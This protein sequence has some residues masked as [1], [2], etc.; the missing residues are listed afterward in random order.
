MKTPR[1]LLGFCLVIA[2]ACGGS[3]D[4]ASGSAP[5]SASSGAASAGS[6]SSLKAVPHEKLAEF[7]PNLSGWK[8][9]A[10]P[11]LDTDTSANVSRVQQSYEKGDGSSISVEIMDAASN[12]QMIVPLR[13][14]L[15]VS[16]TTTTAAGTQK[17]IKVAGH[18]AAEEWAADVRNG[19]V[20]VLLADRFIVTVTGSMVASLDVIHKVF[21]SIDLQKLAALK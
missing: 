17:V 6:S 5:A 14:L 8:R 4:S 9:E 3:A 15:K 18:T 20:A 10:P 7:L 2:G 21:D 12:Q 1:L 13:E 11:N 19:N 16:G